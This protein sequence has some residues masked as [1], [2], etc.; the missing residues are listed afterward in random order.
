MVYDATGGKD[1]EASSPDTF[2]GAVC[3]EV[4]ANNPAGT[5]C[6]ATDSSGKHSDFLDA[7]APGLECNLAGAF[8]GGDNLCHPLCLGV[9][10]GGVEPN[11][12]GGVPP[13]P[14]GQAC[15]DVF[16]LF[17]STT[18]LGLCR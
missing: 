8:M 3:T 7:C 17:A 6:S 12:D 5:E 16:G 10:D 13:C 2:I 4:Y 15:D 14:A 9:P 11:T 1:P 18:P